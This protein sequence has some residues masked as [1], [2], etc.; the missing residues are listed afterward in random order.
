[1]N[2]NITK[3]NESIVKI[4][5]F[6][7]FL[8]ALDLKDLD[9]VKIDLKNEGIN[10][11]SNRIKSNRL[12][13]KL[14][15]NHYEVCVELKKSITPICD[16]CGSENLTLKDKVPQYY[17]M[18]KML[19]LPAWIVYNRKQYRCGHC[20]HNVYANCRDLEKNKYTSNL[21]LMNLKFDFL[22]LS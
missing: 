3:F 14:I 1:M 4:N 22:L 15:E 11:Y 13:A 2:N 20:G 5:F 18:D 7:A 10:N 17:Q 16:K 19:G 8:K 6:G 9:I 12:K 21:L